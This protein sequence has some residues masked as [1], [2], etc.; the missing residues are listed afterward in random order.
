MR[1]LGEHILPDA[2]ARLPR[3]EARREPIRHWTLSVKR[4]IEHTC[5]P[6]GLFPRESAP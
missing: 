6:A 5:G 2:M 3:V 1:V 4:K